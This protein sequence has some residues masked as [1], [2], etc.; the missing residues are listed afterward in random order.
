MKY[1]RAEAP[2]FLK[3]ID[4]MPDDSRIEQAKNLID[5]FKKLIDHG[6]EKVKLA[7]QTYDLVDKLNNKG[8]AS[9]P[10]IG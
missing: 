5:T 2:S 6:T 1:A 9:H 8:R 10:Q 3:K 4:E 7:T